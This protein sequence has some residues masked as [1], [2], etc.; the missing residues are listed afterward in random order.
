[1][2]EICNNKGFLVTFPNGITLSTQFGGGDYCMNFDDPVEQYSEGRK[3]V[4]AEIAIVDEGGNWRTKEVMALAGEP[5]PPDNVVGHV[6]VEVWCKVV[7][8]CRKIPGESLEKG[9]FF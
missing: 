6:T 8:A 5:E 2:F 9:K 7:E 3:C 4:D 1:M